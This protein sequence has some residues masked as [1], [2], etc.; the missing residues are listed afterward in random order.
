MSSLSLLIPILFGLAILASL[1][2]VVVG[3]MRRGRAVPARQE[4]AAE[5]WRTAIPWLVILAVL[6]ILL[7][8]LYWLTR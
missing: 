3:V 1:V 8:G 2:A 5:T 7:P 4:S 6:L